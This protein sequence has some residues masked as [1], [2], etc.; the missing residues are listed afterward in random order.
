MEFLPN[1]NKEIFIS[2]SNTPLRHQEG[3]ALVLKIIL[4][5]KSHAVGLKWKYPPLDRYTD[6]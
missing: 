2:T 3:H 1:Q 5:S 6:T 4:W